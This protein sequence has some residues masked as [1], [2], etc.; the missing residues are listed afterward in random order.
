MFGGRGVACIRRWSRAQCIGAA[1]HLVW[2]RALLLAAAG[3]VLARCR[4]CAR[5]CGS[6]AQVL[7]TRSMQRGGGGRVSVVNGSMNVS[8]TGW[9]DKCLNVHQQLR[10]GEQTLERRGSL[11]VSG[12]GGSGVAFQ[13]L[14]N[15]CNVSLRRAGVARVGRRF[16]RV[17][18][19]RA[20][21][22]GCG[23]DLGP[24]YLC[25][26]TG[27][28][29]RSLHSVLVLVVPNSMRRISAGCSPQIPTIAGV[30]LVP[31]S[32]QQIERS[33][34]PFNPQSGCDIAAENAEGK[35][36]ESSALH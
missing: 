14:L 18:S 33:R 11:I 27:L 34:P 32:K 35:R 22:S 13:R 30:W 3:V 26:V 5:T 2:R 8:I 12:A 4:P 19:S 17:F 9:S 24:L 36:A 20:H 21:A 6:F 7:R 1:A 28:R 25:A 29:R 16:P 31:A 15:G 10:G 23:P